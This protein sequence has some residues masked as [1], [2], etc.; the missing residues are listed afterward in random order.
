[1]GHKHRISVLLSPAFM[2]EMAA[3]PTEFCAPQRKS[4]SA[5]S[6]LY[7]GDKGPRGGC[8]TLVGWCRKNDFR[9]GTMKLPRRKFL[10]L[11]TGA[12]ALPTISC[13][14]K[15]QDYP[16]RPVHIVAGAPPGGILDFYARLTGQW[17]S[18]RL[19]QP[20]IVEN[21][22]GAGGAIA[23]DSV[24]RAPPPRADKPDF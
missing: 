11:A 4:L 1:M 22:A 20:F 3:I 16:A 14:A 9:E 19:G 15:A 12:A 18:E 23:T 8:N 6:G 10:H 7:A 2:S 24:A 17:L 21:R 5:T 13:V